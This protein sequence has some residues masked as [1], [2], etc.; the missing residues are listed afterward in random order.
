MRQGRSFSMTP[1]GKAENS[2]SGLDQ[3]RSST[4]PCQH[5]ARVRAARCVSLLRIGGVVG[6]ALSVLTPGC[7]HEF[8][9]ERPTPKRGSVGEEIYGVLCD[10]VGAQSLR[11]DLVGTSFKNV[12]HKPAGGE[13]A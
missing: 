11:E 13:F 5:S 12:C 9:T 10:R 1:K 6:I 3:N 2:R 4:Y 7:A 8:D